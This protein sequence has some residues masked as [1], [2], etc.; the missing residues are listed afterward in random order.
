MV[1]LCLIEPR[2]RLKSGPYASLEGYMMGTFSWNQ[3][4]R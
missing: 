2:G 1:I 4:S 3:K